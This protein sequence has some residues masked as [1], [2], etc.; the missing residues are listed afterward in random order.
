MYCKKCGKQMD[1]NAIMCP[2]CGAPT[3][4]YKPPEPERPKAKTWPLVI[5]ILSILA[6]II[7]AFQSCAIGVYNTID[8]QGHADGTIGLIIGLMYLSGGIVLIAT[9]YRSRT[10][11]MVLYFIGAFFG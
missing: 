11:A 5:G 4:N 1:D 7:I 6:F 8:G 2:A 3:D 10:A 9:R